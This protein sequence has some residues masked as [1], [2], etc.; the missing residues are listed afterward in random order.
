MKI[1]TGIPLLLLATLCFSAQQA[2]ASP[3]TEAAALQERGDFKRADAVLAAALKSNSVSGDERK[4]VEWEKDRIERI[5]QDYSFTKEGL[6]KTLSRSVKNLTRPEFDKWVAEGRFDSRNIDGVTRY[7]G[8]SVSNLF[9]RHPDLSPRRTPAKDTAG[10]QKARLKLAREIKDATKKQNTPYVLPRHFKCTMSVTV[11]ADAV[12][13][14]ETIRAW[15]PIPRDN[16]FQTGLK[17]LGSSSPVKAVAP[18]SST[19][20]SAYMEQP[21]EKGKKTSF[22]LSY[23]YD[24]RAVHFELDPGNAQPTD[25]TQGDFK[26]YTSEAPHVVFT[27]KIR[28]LGRLIT[29]NGPNPL[30]N[31]KALYNWITKNIQYSFSREYSTLTNISDYCIANRYGDCG[32]EA[33]LFITLCRSQGI[34]ARWQ[35]GWNIFPDAKDIHDWT[36][37]YIAPYG[38]MPV[39]PWAGIFSQQY[40]TALN[41]NERTELKNFYF[42]GLDPYRMI[43]NSDHS[44]QLDPPKQTMRSD[45]VDFQRGEVEWRG[46]NIYFNQYS[47]S[48]RVEEV[49]N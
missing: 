46:G 43:A 26:R 21:A 47:Y 5:R 7:V 30:I 40:C 18:G 29:G 35:T 9:F 31:A 44:Q 20:R 15:L 25:T 22:E 27:D 45:D 24:I 12:P 14:G 33:L 48:L 10:E 39:D 23:E 4:K 41:D 3:L 34:P 19:I 38:W 13:G 36:E 2:L 6:F 37:I 16:Q 49:K 28:N 42:G 17:L 11:D 8:T 32:Q 1:R